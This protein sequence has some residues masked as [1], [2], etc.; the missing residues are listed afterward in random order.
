MPSLLTILILFLLLLVHGFFAGTETAIFSLSKI[1]KRRLEERHPRL[2]KMV[3]AHWENPRR[4]LATILIGNLLINT[5]ATAIVTFLALGLW[6]P[7]GM[8]IALAVFTFLLVL[9]GD[10]APKTFAVRE[11]QR[12]AMAAALPLQIFSVIIYPVR[13]LTRWISDAFVALLIPERKEH[14][15]QISEEE[16]KTLVKIGE[17]E[18]VLDRQEWHMI[19]KLF[20][21][22]ERPARAIMTPRV[23][24]KGLNIEDKEETHIEAI[25]KFH[26]AHFPVY[27]E[28]LDNLLGMISVQDYLLN[29]KKDLTA[30]LEQ[31]LFV[32]ETK[33]I[34]ELYAQLR[35]QNR[36]FAVCVDEYGGTAGIITLEDILE[37]IFGEYYD[38]YSVVEN[39]IRPYGHDEFLVE[40]KIPLIDFNEHFSSDLS[41]KE[42]STVGGFILEKLG[43]VPQKGDILEAA[44]FEFKIHDVIRSRQIRSVLVR[45]R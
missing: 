8:G 1:E 37:E 2:A 17:E 45:K 23:S 42:A 32:P 39:P 22:G 36:N 19:R 44:G 7:E 21:L 29:P 34:D 41:S 25:R 4:T 26:Y 12:F 38:E 33:R 40:A 15:D 10:I 5:L 16:L 13:R 31:P 11:N 28:S 35:R 6:G 24:I 9:I 43:H 3:K 20:E 27:R 30:V 18:G 14:P